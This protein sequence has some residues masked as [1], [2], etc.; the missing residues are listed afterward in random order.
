MPDT[1]T[2]A[3]QAA[4]QV[5]DM[6]LWIALCLALASG[7]SGEMLR[8]SALMEMGWRQIAFR[9]AMRFGAG[10]LAGLAAFLIAMAYGAHP[11]LAASACI[12]IGIAGGDIAATLVERWVTRK[13]GK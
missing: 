12:G 10:T 2:L 13:I 6:P 5:A 8:A 1:H 7:L 3:T 9:I 4:K 11:Y